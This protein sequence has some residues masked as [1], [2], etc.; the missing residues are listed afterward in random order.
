MTILEQVYASGGDVI[1]LA[2]ELTSAAWAEP[3]LI[4]A[5]HC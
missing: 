5:G 1:I 3:V 4:C 2:L